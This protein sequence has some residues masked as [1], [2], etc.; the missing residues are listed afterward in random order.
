MSRARG[1]RDFGRLLREGRQRTI[2][3]AL[4]ALDASSR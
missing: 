4:L 2:A 1:V 3:A